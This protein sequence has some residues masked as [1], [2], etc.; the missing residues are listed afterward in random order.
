MHFPTPK[1]FLFA[2]LLFISNCHASPIE[3]EDAHLHRRDAELKDLILTRDDARLAK[4]VCIVNGCSC[5]RGTDQGQYCWGCSEVL[6]G[7]GGMPTRGRIPRIGC[8]SVIRRGVAACMARGKIVEV[9]IRGFAVRPRETEG[10]TEGR[11]CAKE[12]WG[13]GYLEGVLRTFVG[14]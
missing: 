10:R 14:C 11:L 12:D 5:E 8:L 2:L 4:R 6:F 9:E 13:V 1:L 3:G 7:A